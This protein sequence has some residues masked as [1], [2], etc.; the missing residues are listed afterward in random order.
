MLMFGKMKK[1]TARF[2]AVLMLSQTFSSFAET[3]DTL[4]DIGTTAGST[5][6]IAQEVQMGDYYVRQLRGNAPLIND[7]LLVQYISHVGITL[8]SHASDVRTSFHF[9]LINNQELNAFAFFGGNVVLHS[10]LFRYAD[11]ESQLASVMAHEISHVTQ[12][13]LA[14]AMEDQQHGSSLTWV[15]AFGS[16][17]LAMANPQAGMAA[18]TSTLAGTQ[19]RLI[20]FTRQNEEEADRIGIQVL[21]RAGFDPQG[22]PQLMDKMLDQSRYSTRPPEMLLTHPLPESRLA[23]TRS[24]ADRMPPVV[25]QS[26]E[27]FYLAKIRVLGMYSR[28]QEQLFRELLD[29]W[30]KGNIRQ[31]HAASYGRVIQAM[32]DRDFT[33][34]GKQIQPLLKAEPDSAWYLDM[35]TDL[36]LEQKRFAEVMQRLNASKHLQTD[37]VLQLNLI[38][39]LIQANESDKAVALLN[40]YTFGNKDDTNGWEMLAQ[41]QAKLGH[42][43]Q[44][45]AARAELKALSGKLDEAILLLGNAS[46]LAKTNSLEQ[47]RYDSRIDQIRHLQEIF[48]PYEKN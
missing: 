41:V 1:T 15:G 32:A 3:A 6:S 47:A 46:T 34:A 24:R 38:N 10:A 13:H 27:D 30:S 36:G 18:L 14:R 25:I 29:T 31:Q 20:S 33:E 4:P 9:F 7:P 12:R 21:Q 16:I 17:L 39:A 28:G 43:D 23:D 26:S 37:G 22:M 2:I 35:A 42:R 45:L 8:A 48:K 5:L 44:E 11:T 19:Q 40:R